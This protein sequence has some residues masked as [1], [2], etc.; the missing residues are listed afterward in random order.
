MVLIEWWERS[1]KSDLLSLVGCIHLYLIIVYT[2][3]CVG[4]LGE[5]GELDGGVEEARGGE[6]ELIDISF[7][8]G[9]VWLGGVESEPNKEYD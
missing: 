4:I 1:I 5:E 8:E 9:E 7:S 3:F 6:V 2:D